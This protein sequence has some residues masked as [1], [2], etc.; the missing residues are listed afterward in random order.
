MMYYK[1]EIIEILLKH[2]T[3]SIGRRWPPEDKDYEPE[4]KIVSGIIQ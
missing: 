3:L 1:K 2:K 4:L